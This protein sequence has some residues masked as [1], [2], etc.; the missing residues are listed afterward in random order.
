MKK[1]ILNKETRNVIMEIELSSNDPQ[2]WARALSCYIFDCEIEIN[3][4]SQSAEVNKTFWE[5]VKTFFKF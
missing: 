1:Q 2:V 4:L 3:D 5:K